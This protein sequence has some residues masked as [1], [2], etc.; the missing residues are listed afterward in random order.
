LHELSKLMGVSFYR[1]LACPSNPVEW[2]EN[3]GPQLVLLSVSSIER[4]G[5]PSEETLDV[6]ESY[7]LLRTDQN[8]WIELST[9]GEQMWIASR[10]TTSDGWL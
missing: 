6:V 3:L 7:T 2:V 5:M 4:D 10:R 8:G 9:D 1:K